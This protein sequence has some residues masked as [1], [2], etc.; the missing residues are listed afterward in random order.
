MVG[1]EIWRPTFH[2]TNMS[3][4]KTEFCCER[5]IAGTEWNEVKNEDFLWK[6]P[7]EFHVPA[8]PA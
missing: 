3:G 4:F 1:S 8:Y 5:P 2:R 7:A 6:A